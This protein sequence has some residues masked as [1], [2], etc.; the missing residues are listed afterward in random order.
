VSLA[1]NKKALSP[2]MALIIGTAIIIISFILILSLWT[3]LFSKAEPAAA[4]SLC[5]SFN[6][7]R[8]RTD[9]EIG[10]GKLS[11]IPRACK[12]IEKTENDALPEAIYTQTTKGV[13]ENI[14]KLSAKC[15]KMWLEGRSDEILT[16]DGFSGL[17]EHSDET[18]CFICY[19]FSIKKSKEIMPFSG[20]DLDLTFDQNVFFA[21]DTSDKCALTDTGYAGGHCMSECGEPFTKEIKSD[22]CT[23]PGKTRCCIVNERKDE[24][25]NK[26]GQC[27]FVCENNQAE[28]AHPIGWQCADEDQTCCIK[29]E[30]LY[31][32]RDYIQNYGGLGRVDITSTTFEPGEVYAISFA[33]GVGADFWDYTA[34]V[35][36]GFLTEYLSA[37]PKQPRI[38]I[39]ELDAVTKNCLVELE[40]E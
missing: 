24:C 20:S 10:P 8:T 7:L 4:E 25:I 5:E 18:K 21:E 26:G 2:T 28:Y 30:N 29:K 23:T 19:A 16:G 1:H 13:Q 33:N 17:F 27:N 15:W 36:G 37:D 12:I 22:K 39:T 11:L 35:A 9:L 14:R 32:Y 34:L 31:T 3:T 6:A 38:L 40:G